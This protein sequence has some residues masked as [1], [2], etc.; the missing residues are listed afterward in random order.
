MS[1]TITLLDMVLVC[2]AGCALGF[3]AGWWVFRPARP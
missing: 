1:Y 3:G 2:M